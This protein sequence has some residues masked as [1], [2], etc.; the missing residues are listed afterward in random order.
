MAGSIF[1]S[2]THSGL[3]LAMLVSAVVISTGF[4]ASAWCDTA[5]QAILT[6]GLVSG[7]A[8]FALHGRF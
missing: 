5:I 2:L 1:N 6:F 4:V 8:N 3:R 7:K